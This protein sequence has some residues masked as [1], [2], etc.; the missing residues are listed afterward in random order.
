MP[1]CFRY[2]ITYPESGKTHLYKP[3]AMSSGESGLKHQTFG[4]A[5][6][7]VGYDKLVSNQRVQVVW[8]APT[9]VPRW[10]VGAS[11]SV[12]SKAFC[13]WRRG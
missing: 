12:L 13:R 11:R 8:E 6:S 5:W 7:T 2:N 9:C 3:N 4:A 10:S 1:I